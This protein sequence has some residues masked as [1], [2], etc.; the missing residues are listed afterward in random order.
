MDID[1]G[2]AV[3]VNRGSGSLGTMQGGK[4]SSTIEADKRANVRLVARSAG[5]QGVFKHEAFRELTVLVAALP[6][7]MQ[8][9]S[10]NYH[11]QQQL[12]C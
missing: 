10:R 9:S 6:V 8:P 3:S 1:S 2:M 5:Q 12:L 11:I 7:L 4:G